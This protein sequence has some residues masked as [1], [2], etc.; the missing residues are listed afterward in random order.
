MT[1]RP[2]ARG[3][4][5]LSGG[6]NRAREF[7]SPDE[8][9]EIYESLGGIRIRMPAGAYAQRF[10]KW[11]MKASDRSFAD[12]L[13]A[14]DFIDASSHHLL[15]EIAQLWSRKRVRLTADGFAWSETE[16]VF[17][18]LLH[19]YQL[20]ALYDESGAKMMFR[21]QRDARWPIVSSRRRR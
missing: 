21:G 5:T 19:V 6:G 2:L 11:N 3:P 15:L 8:A 16:T 20:A 18:A 14:S 1:R 10:V 4:G 13:R 9:R 7:L 17:E 12:F